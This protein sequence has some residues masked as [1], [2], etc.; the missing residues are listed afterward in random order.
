MAVVGIP[1][2]IKKDERRVALTPAGARELTRRGHRVVIERKAG[3]GAGFADDEYVAAG[4]EPAG[5]EDV[6]AEAEIILKVK[7]P[8]PEEVVRLATRHTLFTYLHL[9]AD[10]E[11]AWG[12]AASG[13]RCIAYETVEDAAGRLPLL[14]PM[15]DIAG[16][17]AAQAGATA[18]TGP[19]G[20]RGLLVGGTPG[21]APAEVL[22]LGGGMAGAAAATVAAG[23][24]ARVTIVDR[25]IP[26]LLELAER[27]GTTVRTLHASEMAIEELLPAADLVIGAVLVTGARAP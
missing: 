13:A 19:G 20:G 5:V 24:G 27:F 11:L 26:R 23:M 22:V 14:A 21:V 16:R 9:A 6:F 17:L 4:A 15:S 18:L 12:L 2:E 25:S 8:Q 7:E 10:P 1:T 3:Q